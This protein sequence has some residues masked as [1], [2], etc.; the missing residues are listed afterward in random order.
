MPTYK[1]VQAERTAWDVC[2]KAGLVTRLHETL[3]LGEQVAKYHECGNKIIE[4]A[5]QIKAER[6]VAG[7]GERL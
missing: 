4:L 7:M 5:E 3:S 2:A 6:A 1:I